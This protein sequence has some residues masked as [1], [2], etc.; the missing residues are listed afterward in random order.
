ML[1]RKSEKIRAEIFSPRSPVSQEK[2]RIVHDAKNFKISLVPSS[3]SLATNRGKYTIPD[4]RSLLCAQ[5][6]C[7]AV[8]MKFYDA[9]RS[10]RLPDSLISIANPKHL[11][12]HRGFSLVALYRA[13]NRRKIVVS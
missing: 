2:R 4:R 11:L 10:T 13:V 6:N 7:L 9:V 3:R 12:R 1:R 8:R 5:G